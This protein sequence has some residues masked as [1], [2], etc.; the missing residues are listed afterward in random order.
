MGT[1]INAFLEVD[2][3][4]DDDPFTIEDNIRPFNTGKFFI[5]NDYALFDALG[6]GRNGAWARNPAGGYEP[7]QKRALY[8]P[9]GLPPLIS[10]DV[11]EHY[12]LEVIEPD[13]EQAVLLSKPLPLRTQPAVITRRDA[14]RVVA[15]GRAHFAPE[16]EV[17]EIEIRGDDGAFHGIRKVRRVLVSDPWCH[18]PSWLTLSE[19]HAA[20]DHFGIRVRDLRVEVQV[21]LEAMAGFERAFGR[22]R[23]RLVFWFDN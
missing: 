22:E 14:D 9:R 17:L 19:V 23:A 4:T 18:H 11:V 21:I 10:F 2:R 7:G 13:E 16:V 20:L 5:W 15:E 12:Y 6:D 3:G 1:R 8:P